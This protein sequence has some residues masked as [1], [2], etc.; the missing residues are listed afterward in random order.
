[1]SS[2]PCIVSNF[3]SQYDLKL[4]ALFM[5]SKG[6][7]PL[8]VDS[9]IH[10]P[11]FLPLP[12]PGHTISLLAVSTDKVLLEQKGSICYG[13]VFVI[14]ALSKIPTEQ[15][16]KRM[17][18]WVTRLY[19][20]LLCLCISNN[21]HHAR[22]TMHQ[23]D[24]RISQWEYKCSLLLYKGQNNLIYYTYGQRTP[25]LFASNSLKKMLFIQ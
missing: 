8:T 6:F 4:V 16:D 10:L 25:Q 20:I 2:T 14:S 3:T 24:Q 13:C 19:L 15:T 21:Q 23:Q 17:P 1:M 9:W 12:F 11:F 5:G 22:G 18:T 7:Q